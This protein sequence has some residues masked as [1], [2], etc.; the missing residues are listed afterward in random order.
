MDPEG[1]LGPLTTQWTLDLQTWYCKLQ[2]HFLFDAADYVGNVR[3]SAAR[4]RLRLRYLDRKYDTLRKSVLSDVELGHKIP[5]DSTPTK[6]FR[7][8][9]PPSLA[10]DK[11]RAWKAILKDLAHGAIKSANIPRDG[12]PTCVTTFTT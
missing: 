12:M 9:N 1:P 8:R 11:H 5:F 6:F 4:L 2:E 3:R 10:E 7:K